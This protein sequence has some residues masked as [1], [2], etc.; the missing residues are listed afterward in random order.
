[1]PVGPPAVE[2]SALDHVPVAVQPGADEF[3]GP[4]CL[5]PLDIVFPE[6]AVVADLRG[7]EHAL[8]AGAVVADGLPALRYRIDIA[9][10]DPAMPRTAGIAGG[11]EPDGTPDAD[12][13][14]AISFM[15]G[16]G[17]GKLPISST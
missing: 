8:E 11:A 2:E 16:A 10:P 14:V 12:R 7:D 17:D 13:S 5:Q 4:G 1:M 9:L 6:V 3:L 15:M